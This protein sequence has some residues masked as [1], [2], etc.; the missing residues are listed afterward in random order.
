[1]YLKSLEMLGFKSFADKTRLDFE[2]GMT[3]IV[4]P[5]GC[6]KSNIADAIRWVIGETSPKALRG[7]QMVDCIFN[8]TDT[9]KPL[10]MAEVSITLADCEKA[11]GL[12]YNEVTVTRRVMRTGEGMYFINK[13]PCRLKDI[14]RLFMDTGIGTVSYSVMEQGRIDRVLSSRP[15]DRREIFEEASGITKFKSDKEEAIRKLDHTEANLLRLADVIREV[16]R[17]IGSLQRQ[18]SKARTYKTLQ[19]QMRSLDL[20]VTRH[21]LHN[22]DSTISKLEHSI[23]ETGDRLKQAIADVQKDESAAGELRSR[24]MHA[25]REIGTLSEAA[26]RARNELEHAREVIAMN[27]QRSGELTEWIARDTEEMSGVSSLLGEK[28]TALDSLEAKRGILS[29]EHSEAE[30]QLSSANE[31]FSSHRQLVDS[32]RAQLNKWREEAVQLESMGVR[33]ANELHEAEARER[34]AAFQKERLLAEKSQLTR[35]AG[36]FDRRREEMTHSLD[37][38]KQRLAEEENAVHG[39]ESE[40]L[41][42]NSQLDS[43]VQQA[44]DA[45]AT[46]ASLR[47]RMDAA[48]RNHPDADPSSASRAL[49]GSGRQIAGID[50]SMFLGIL[51]EHVKI[52]DG[53][54][55]AFDAAMAGRHDAVLLADAANLLRVVEALEKDG[56]GPARILAP[57]AS[58]AAAPVAGLEPLINHV[59]ASCAARPHVQALLAGVVVVDS[60]LSCPWPL[61]SG[62]TIVT[63]RGS[64][65]SHDGS[66]DVLSSFAPSADVNLTVEEVSA[67][68]KRAA[69]LETELTRAR[70]AHSKLQEQLSAASA[71]LS[72]RRIE[73]AT[74]DGEL[75]VVSR[76]ATEARQRLETVTW[77]V[78]NIISGSQADT[79]E[80]ETIGTRLSEIRRQRETVT[81]T[82]S[83]IGRDLSQA[84][85]RQ[86]ELHLRVTE[87]RVRVAELSQKT[88]SIT[89]QC[90]ALQD[91][92]KEHEN[93]I[94]TRERAIEDH[95][96]QIG[97]LEQAVVQAEGR[98]GAL[99]IAV[100]TNDEQAAAAHARRDAVEKEV[101]AAD[102]ALS[103]KRLVLDELR[104]AKSE[105]EIKHAEFR[106]RRQNTL[107]RVTG[108]Y[109]ITLEQLEAAPEPAWEGEKPPVESVETRLAEIR[110]KM[111]AMGPV[112]LVAIEEYKELEERYTFLTQQEQDL[113][114]A[115]QQLMEMIRKI[116]RTTSEMFQTTFDKINTNFQEV[117]AKLFNGGSAK[118]VLVN[119]EEV[120][121]CGIE[122][123][124]R[125]PGKRLQN[126]SL[127]SGGERTLTAVALLFAIYMIKPSPFCLLDELDAPLDDSNIGRFI[128]ILQGFLQQS[129]FVTITHSRQTIAAASVIYGITMEEK[130]ISRIVSMKFRDHASAPP[131][132]P[133]VR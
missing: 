29:S 57:V 48:R 6:G 58:P 64:R 111:E 60:A 72:E 77:E 130:G 112:N 125:P 22:L 14:Q 62:I 49:L 106:M 10:G 50:S 76:E 26:T 70:A 32:L 20:Y 8:G 53:Y 120:L 34:S 95:K 63:R 36:D 16:K 107:D 82:M 67:A 71:R 89:S 123:I 96:R 2:P 45:R 4:G 110:T 104:A 101:A 127:L 122:I 51:S 74:R 98:I 43:L 115:K 54:H 80:K 100:N 79:R 12:E 40:L 75:A 91:A 93:S 119:E 73:L 92:V 117:F 69:D 24:M 99:E 129:Q 11:L 19:E 31:A 121:E 15:E 83:I 1:M 113:V 108:E 84:E 118:L 27:R 85:S 38:V 78:E 66:A 37:P 13:T 94:R 68:E 65:V 28:R 86:S 81:E 25:E 46:T 124:A 90:R 7:S 61:P 44:A 30:S 42:A 39:L 3:A 59:R 23:L 5:N 87:C 18:A 9:R 131:S 88:D 132:V 56:P 47:A 35:V 105:T 114:K 109:A 21:Q 126:I 52:D 102:E 17:Q 103:K 55:A 33:L 128:K 97:L 41:T 116:N 133:A